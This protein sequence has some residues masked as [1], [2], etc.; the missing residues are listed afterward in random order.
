MHASSPLV[1]VIV[2]VFGA[3]GSIV[4]CAKSLFGQTYPQTE[5]IFI[6]DG[7][8]DASIGLLKGVLE[9]DFPHL[10][11]RTRILSGA[12]QGPS[13]ARKTGL[14]AANGEYVLMADADD[15]LEPR[16]VELLVEKAEKEEADMVVFDF[17]KEYP[18]RKKLDREK[19]DS[20][21]NPDLY[22]RRLFTYRAYGYLWNKFTRRSL[23]EGLF[24]PRYPMQEDIVLSAQ[25]IH[26]ARKTVHLRE[27]L[28]HY[29][30]SNAHALTRTPK[31][32]RRSWAARNLMDFYKRF[33]GEKDSPLS[34]VEKVILRRAR[35][36]ALL[37]DR[38]LLND[39]PQLK[40]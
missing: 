8:T 21:E 33:C 29:N 27:P 6:D 9:V 3:Q 26:K 5:F 32:L 10:E 35:W 7:C 13:L 22:R 39:Y 25:L 18:F 37:Y 28:Y 34:G 16:A 19:E 20:L 4:S 23:W 11:S 15:T 31:A 14:E 38:T 1:S 24:F 30:R 36:T 17:W 2:P 12:H 40:K